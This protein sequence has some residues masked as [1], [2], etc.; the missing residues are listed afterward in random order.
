MTYVWKRLKCKFHINMIYKISMKKN[1][2]LINPWIYDFA[3]YDF[4]IKPLGLLYIGSLFRKN[5]YHVKL[6]DCLNP[7]HPHLKAEKNISIYRRNIAG[8]GKFPA[9]EI[10]KP[11][12]LKEIKKRYKRYG[13]TPNIFIEELKLSK[14]PDLIL[15]TSIMTYWYP[16]VFETIRITKEMFPDVPL[17]LGGIYV[18]L[19]PEHALKSGADLTIS[20]EG[21][22][23]IP[24]LLREFFGEEP[25]YT[26]DYQNLDSLPYPAFDLMPVKDQIPIMTSRGCT[27]NCTY[28]ASHILHKNFRQRDP[29]KTVD[30][31]SFWNTNFGIKHFSFYDDALLV[32]QKKMAIPMLKEIIKRELQCEF[33]CPN[34]LHLR[35]ITS[36]SSKLMHMAG[37]RTIRFGFESSSRDRQIETGGKVNNTQLKTAVTYLKEAGY[38]SEDIGIYILCGLPGQEETEV[39]DTIRYVQNC[40]ARPI[41]TEYSPI[42]GTILWEKSIQESS[43]NLREEPLFHNNSLLSCRNKKLTYDVYQNLKIM[44][45]MH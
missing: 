28:C 30:E 15:V 25:V 11:Y 4:W 3:A 37:F 27:Y 33:H 39:L 40:G 13:I 31:I 38:K 35:E 36:K 1:I 44:T 18:T 8:H 29:I 7:L 19:C 6:I 17:I 2:L 21:E 23:F 12:P 41:I 32:N 34:G 5:G 43:F 26:P 9:E 24:S 20:G 10:L 16:G 42:P 45:K 14:K 22:K